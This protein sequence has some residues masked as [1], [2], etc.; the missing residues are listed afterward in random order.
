M[1]L[2]YIVI[3]LSLLNACSFDNK[4]GIWNNKNDI[5]QKNDEIFKDF[6]KI[7]ITKDIFNEIII[8]QK[9]YDIKVDKSL[10]NLS[11]KD[12]NFS[13]NNNS[14]NFEYSNENKLYLK[15]GKLTRHKIN[16][17]TLYDEKNFVISNERGSIIIFSTIENKT[18]SKFNFYKKKYKRIKKKLNLIISNN[19][20]FI[21]D[22]LGY[23]YAFDYKK[24]KVIWAKNFKIPF[25]SNLKI[26][27]N[28]L[29]AS[30]QNNEIYFLNVKDGTLLKRT[31][32]EQVNIKNYFTNNFSI[33]NNNLYFLNSYGTLYSIDL[34]SKEVNW[35]LN[36]NNSKDYNPSNLF[37][38]NQIN[39]NKF[40][41]ISSSNASTYFFDKKRGSILKK[42][43]FTSNFLPIINGNFAFFI[44]NNNLFLAVDL[45]NY[46]ILFSSNINDQLINYFRKK[47]LNKIQIIDFKLINNEI[48][49]FLKNSNIIKFELNGRI[50]EVRKFPS[51]INTKP[52]I[53]GGKI[54]YISSKNELNI[55]N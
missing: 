52:I 7:S 42:Y 40:N 26:F 53:A 50:K 21:S 54:F 47:K 20:I 31:P 32:T 39:A 37:F 10:K 48:V 9:D 16:F 34:E 1:K 11:W 43:N 41:V 29:I 2:L 45:R 35:F 30:N 17:F 4:T 15:S 14:I 18:I 13:K 8:V 51:K 44:T 33:D 28:T 27:K 49:I 6:K 46:K 38:G 3:F 25:N 19:I 55:I 12:I 5:S 23:L 22:N 36:L 24:N